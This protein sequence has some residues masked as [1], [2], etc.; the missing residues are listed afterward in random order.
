MSHRLQIWSGRSESDDTHGQVILGG[1]VFGRR[2]A[3]ECRGSVGWRETTVTKG[4]GEDGWGLSRGRVYL[5]WSTGTKPRL[6]A[7]RAVRAET[8]PVTGS[9]T[10]SSV[11]AG[12]SRRCSVSG[13]WSRGGSIG[14]GVGGWDSVS[15][16]WSSWSWRDSISVWGSGWGSVS[17]RETS[18]R[19][20][21]WV[22][23][24][25]GIRW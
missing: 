2:V 6:A 21:E 8:G 3:S 10:R 11:R 1:I 19:R 13:R 14:V 22:L 23:L 15:V 20:R 4:W 24:G 7:C 25:C 12:R 16:W 9:S 17:V 18:R 5:G